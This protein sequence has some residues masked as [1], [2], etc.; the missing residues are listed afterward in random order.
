MDHSLRSKRRHHAGFARASFDS[1]CSPGGFSKAELDYVF[2]RSAENSSQAVAGNLNP[3]VHTE[4]AFNPTAHQA[5]RQE[6][7]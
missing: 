1:P 5:A 7:A 6:T 2:F 4:P 3:I